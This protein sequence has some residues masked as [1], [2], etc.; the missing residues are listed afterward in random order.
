MSVVSDG[1][2]SAQTRAPLRRHTLPWVVQAVLASSDAVVPALAGILFFAYRLWHAE[3]I[4]ACAGMTVF[5]QT[6]FSGC[7]LI[8]AV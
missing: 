5:F 2:R 6:A 1:G 7:F 4:P 8:Q 3:Q